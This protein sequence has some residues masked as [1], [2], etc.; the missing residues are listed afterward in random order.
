M[1][2]VIICVC[3]WVYIYIYT[4]VHM[5]NWICI[6]ESELKYNWIILEILFLMIILVKHRYDK[7]EMNKVRRRRIKYIFCLFFFF[8]R[9]GTHS[10]LII[11]KRLVWILN[12]PNVFIINSMSFLVWVNYIYFC[13]AIKMMK[14][15]KNRKINLFSRVNLHLHS[16]HT[17]YSKSQLRP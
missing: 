13:F 6:L 1:F 9:R 8:S 11:D 14:P 12:Y 16:T 15:C 5:Y 17:W 3:L 10:I 2:I 4:Y 7:T